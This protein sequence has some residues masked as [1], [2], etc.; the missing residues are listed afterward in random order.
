LTAVSEGRREKAR[1]RLLARGVRVVHE[2]GHLLGIAK[3]AGVLSQ[4]G[5][6]GEDSLVEMLDEYR[7]AAEGKPGRAYVGLVHRL[8]RGVSGAMVVAKTSKAASR[9]SAAFRSRA[10]VEKTYLAWV[11]GQPPA[12]E[13]SLEGL[14]VRAR[15]GRVTRDASEGDA[16]AREAR[17]S[18][19]TVGR[20]RAASRLRIRLET[21]VTH[22]IRAQLSAAG[23]PIV[24]DG[25][26]GGRPAPAA[27]RCRR[28]ALHAS[29]LVVPHPVG[30]LPVSIEAPV[31]AD[32]LRLDAAL[33]MVPPLD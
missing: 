24:G 17:L 29:S 15:G 30:G 31:P 27:A 12:G 32:L 10:G 7:R 6:Q 28:P 4:P 5:P 23:W 19:E 11:H 9:L 8:D 18:F 20:S 33:R 16:G 1:A 21:G 25:K 2:D 26:Y 3:E 14:L 22:Q 13:R